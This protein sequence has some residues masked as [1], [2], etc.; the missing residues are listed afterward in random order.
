MYIKN[1]NRR[2]T[3]SVYNIPKISTKTFIYKI[4]L[5][6]IEKEV[7]KMAYPQYATMA[8]DLWGVSPEMAL[9]MMAIVGIW[10]LVWKGFALWKSAG[11]KQLVWFIV[12]LIINTAGL[13]E[14]L[15]IFIFSKLGKRQKV[16]P[17][18]SKPK[19]R[20]SKK[21]K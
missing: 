2:Y 6:K 18:K 16:T 5:K 19:K 11:K 7:T 9:G 4:Y 14:I 8:S 20:S 3:K 17:V 12:L 1:L 13:L 10:S 15:Y 21:K